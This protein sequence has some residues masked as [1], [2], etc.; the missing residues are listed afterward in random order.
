MRST[1]FGIEIAVSALRTYQRAQDVVGHNVANAG[2]P[3][4]S[5][6]V[7]EIT[8]SSP[9]PYP[10]LNKPAGIGQVGT[11]VEIAQL[12]RVRDEFLTYRYREQL[13]YSKWWERIKESL[14]KV[15]GIFNEP[16][17]GELN[18]ILNEFWKCWEDLSKNPES[19]AVRSAVRDTGIKL[20]S[21]INSLYERLV[22]LRVL[23][24]E[25]INSE[26]TK[27]NSL[28]DRIADINLKIR[29][30]EATGDRA[31][32]LRDKRDALLNELNEIVSIY[33]TEDEIGQVNVYIGGKVAIYG[34]KPMVYGDRK[35][36]LKFVPSE[37]NPLFGKVVWSDDLKKADIRGGS[38]GALLYSRDVVI[39][40]Y[41][42]LLNELT[43]Q[44]VLEVN[45]IHSTSYGLR[46]ANG[47]PYTGYRFFDTEEL[48]TPLT[49]KQ[50]PF[51]RTYLYSREVLPEKT[52]EDT[53]LFEL[54]IT[55]GVFTVRGI[56]IS[57]TSSDVGQG[58]MRLKD[59]FKL[60]EERTQVKGF[61]NSVSRKI[62]FL[63]ENSNVL[64]VGSDT[65]TSNF[66]NIT[67]LNT[68][69]GNLKAHAVAV[70]DDIAGRIGVSKEIRE[71]LR[72]IAASSS[73]SGVP[74]DGSSALKIA[75]L[76]QTKT[77]Y[78]IPPTGTYEEFYRD[79]IG[80]L[81]IETQT[82]VSRLE[83]H[84]A[85]KNQLQNKIQEVSGVS[86]DEEAAN[87]IKY[88]KI[89]QA[90]ARFFNTIDEMI[91]TIINVVGR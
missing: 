63:L 17:E 30:I 29:E 81:G 62:V 59:L 60:I 34:G 82:A 46:D 12:K 51:W 40:K 55:E 13:Q 57:L 78:G 75:Q 56:Q 7:P 91:D 77:M 42:D 87:M 9:F 22:M 47:I 90:A 39:P 61:Y 15:E 84:T 32:D 33:Y 27:I 68:K 28:T 25:E 85:L 44:I 2:N 54:G 45:S 64:E 52:T 3:D 38:L 65:D 11:G 20:A 14:E 80:S 86:L 72:K 36:E 71:D 73:S 31:N 24:N 26:V 18:E 48:V 53:S 76:K 49:D 4:Y 67:G 5:R 66:L 23:D 43:K 79:I 35:V 58:G 70:S 37:E 69:A 21:S 6:Q 89:Y 88:Q 83:S 1:F 19:M 74:G 50:T 8:S 10:G 41:I 16:S